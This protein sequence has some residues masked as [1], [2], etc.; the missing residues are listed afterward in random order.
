MDLLVVLAVVLGVYLAELL[1]DLDQLFL[2]RVD[3]ISVLGV[4]GN[5]LILVLLILGLSLLIY[6]MRR[7]RETRRSEETYR[8]LFERNP[9]A[10]W[11]YDVKTLRFLAVNDT[12]I[13]LYGFSRDEF[14]RMTI[15]D[16]RPVE[17]TPALLESTAHVQP[18]IEH[19]GNWRHRLKD[20][21]IIDVEITSQP[22]AIEGQ[23]ARLVMAAD[24]SERKR[25]LQALEASEN[26]FRALIENSSDGI[27]LLDATGT[28]LYRS[29]ANARILGYRL[30]D[31]GGNVFQ[32][33]HPDDL[34]AFRTAFGRIRALAGE[35][36]MLEY[37]VRHRDGSWRWLE[38]VA[39]NL[40]ADP[41]VQ[42]VVANYRD[43]TERKL[44]EE[45][46]QQQVAEAEAITRIS[47]SLRMAG[48]LSE[49]L[50]RVLDATLAIVH[51][52]RGSIW[53]HD[54]VLDEVRIA[55]QRNWSIANQ[56]PLRRGEGI[57]GYVL[58]TGEPYISADFKTDVRITEA[59]RAIIPPG[60]SGACI[61]ISSAE[62]PVGV[63]FVQV[64]APRE[65]SAAEVRLL[66]TVAE[67]AGIAIHRMRLNAQ[68][69]QRLRQLASQREIDIAILGR[70]DLRTTLSLLL[71][72]IMAQLGA[73]AADVL[74]LDM[75]SNTLEFA[76]AA[77]FR[78]REIEQLRVRVGEGQSGRAALE[79]HTVIVNLR[80][81]GL[82][83]AYGPLTTQEGFVVYVA[84]PLIAKGQVNGVL[85]IFR[86]SAF[87]P[88]AEWL[89]LLETL[90]GQAALAIDNA[91]LFRGLQQA[92]M[93]LTLAYDT[94][95]EGWSR[96][97][98]L[99]DK[100]T[101][102]HTQR[103]TDLTLELAR[104]MG[105][106]AADLLQVRRGA[107]LHDIGKMGVP[108]R[109]LLKPGPLT[110]E[111]WVI[112]RM[113]PVYARDLLSPIA[114]LQPALDIPYCHHEKWDGTG[115]P[116]GLKGEQIPLTARIFAIVDVWD[117]L[118]SDR[119]YRP[120]WPAEKVREHI[121]SLA[122]THF[123][124]HVVEVFLNLDK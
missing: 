93:E 81:A 83:A 58:Q 73:D 117:A 120:A 107:L 57:P 79:L 24:V 31:A 47:H 124:N 92:H 72:Q 87:T 51:A 52:S 62:A 94:T 88:D 86:R 6:S 37:R 99:R 41:S 2:K 18:G 67:I 46:I 8:Y 104:T 116:R 19:S 56:P 12:A 105:L 76:A 74:L 44:A 13:A 97:L 9:N 64:D 43:I 110:D 103:V 61:P 50:D 66:T 29:P 39:T 77:G 23:S 78:S 75:K 102:G 71:T 55:T 42:A 95:L 118:R 122:G 69:E 96:A 38:A 25:A 109:I 91:Q 40:L 54:P 30:L 11:T 14:A 26:H 113:H 121:R 85:S 28:V 114:Y 32:L 108:D 82:P 112:M 27:V 115:Y 5:D 21:K 45:R 123:D 33:V 7:Q 49:M 4:T 36:V 15:K 80:E 34:A 119:P 68:T 53:L 35:S 98:D 63:M 89:E 1:V 60:V 20:G 16:I 59:T 100:E 22:L 17:D 106:D 10:M 111:E 101:E 3:A 65:L 90:A 84:V 48:T 70:V